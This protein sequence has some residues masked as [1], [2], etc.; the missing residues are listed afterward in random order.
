MRGRLRCKW[1]TASIVTVPGERVVRVLEQLIQERGAPE[2][3]SVDNDPETSGGVPT[4]SSSG[5]SSSTSSVSSVGSSSDSATGVSSTTAS[6]SDSGC[7]FMECDADMPPSVD[8]CS[9]WM[10]DCPKGQKCMSYSND[11]GAAYTATKC[12]PVDLNPDMVGEECI[13]YDNGA[14]GLDSCGEGTMCWILDWESI[15]GLCAPFCTGAVDDPGC[16]P[17]TECYVNGSG[18]GVV[19]LPL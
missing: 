16:A 13:A 12:F 5:G 17:G 14:D 15:E 6:T 7:L 19:C 10:Q 9:L 18:F 3:T 11:G 8:E 2:L 1:L 4:G